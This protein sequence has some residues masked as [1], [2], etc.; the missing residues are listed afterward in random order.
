MLAEVT[1]TMSEIDD[2][3]EFLPADDELDEPVVLGA[4][5]AAICVGAPAEWQRTFD[6]PARR[7]VATSEQDGIAVIVAEDE[8]DGS[9]PRDVE[10]ELDVAEL[11]ERQHYALRSSA[12]N[13]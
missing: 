6:D 1:R 3:W 10:R 7:D 11:L 13:R 4:E 5:E 8:D 2:I 9:T 12:G